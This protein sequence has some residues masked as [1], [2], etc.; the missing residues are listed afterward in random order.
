M[1]DLKSLK[2]TKNNFLDGLVNLTICG[3]KFV[4]K[5]DNS[6]IANVAFMDLF[7]Y[8]GN[9]FHINGNLDI[10]VYQKPEN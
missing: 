9:K 1:M 10:K 4:Y 8:K 7:I 3:K 5:N 6:K 2:A